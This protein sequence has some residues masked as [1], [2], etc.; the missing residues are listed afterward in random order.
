[1][2][3]IITVNTMKGGSSKSTLALNLYHYFTV[4]DYYCGLIDADPQASLQESISDLEEEIALLTRADIENWADL[5][6]LDEGDYIVID[7]APTRDPEETIDIFRASDIILMPCQ[8]SILSI[9]ALNKTVGY[10]E[11]AKEEN[12]DLKA[13]IVLTQ[14]KAG[15]NVYDSL[16]KVAGNYQIPVLAT[17]MLHRVD[18]ASSIILEKGVFST[19]NEKAKKEIQGIAIELQNML[20][21]GR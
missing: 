21:H 6:N 3:K 13:A 7:T 20:N 10:Y 16:R 19:T 12:A 14:G 11:S 8:P 5:K 4:S 2:P 15:T 18:Y 9:R 1:M 17:E